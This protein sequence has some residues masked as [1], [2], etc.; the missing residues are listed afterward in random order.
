MVESPFGSSR[1]S[2]ATSRTAT[3]S[4]RS[5]SGST[6]PSSR[7]AWARSP[8][9]CRWTC[10][11][12]TW[13]AAHE[14]RHAGENRGRRRLRLSACRPTANRARAEH[15]RRLRAHRALARRTARRAR[16]RR[17]QSPGARRAV[18]AKEPKTGTDGTMSWTVDVLN[19]R[20]G[21]DFVLGLK[22]ITLPDGVSAG[23]TRCGS[24]ANTRA[25]STACASCCRS[26]CA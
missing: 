22:E 4:T 25:R 15:G 1:S 26:T 8:R 12:R 18:L 13:L 14:A 2:S 9:R 11:P 16:R 24:P 19:P 20:T 23:R 6:A 7:A 17:R 10:A 5:R 3:V 21:D